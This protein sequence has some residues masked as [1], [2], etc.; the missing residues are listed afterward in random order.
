MSTLLTIQGL[1]MAVMAAHPS[2]TV[3]S[4]AISLSLAVIC[5]WLAQQGE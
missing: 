2:N 4:R 3:V 5:I 1:L